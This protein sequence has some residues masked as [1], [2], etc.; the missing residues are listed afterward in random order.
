[1][2]DVIITPHGAH[3]H[4]GHL[5]F[6]PHRARCALGRG[7]VTNNKQEGDAKTPLG[8]F[9]LRRIWYRPDRVM[10][11]HSSFPIA[12]IC[13]K[14][15]WCD[16]VTANCYNRPIT[17]PIAAR[18]ERLWR[19]DRLYDVFFELGYND[20]PPESGR[21]S[22]IFLHLEKNNFNPTLGCIA[23][24]HASMSFLLRHAAPGCYARIMSR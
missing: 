5:Q 13:E 2:N 17:R 19:Q 6:G 4:G 7:G 1:M 16:D 20:A 12:E 9:P 15:G 24:S 21:G 14:S 10:R 22:A 18:H 3:K 8:V 11:P 23:V